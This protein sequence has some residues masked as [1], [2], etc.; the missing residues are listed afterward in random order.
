VKA[1]RALSRSGR[2]RLKTAVTSRVKRKPIAAVGGTTDGNSQG[3]ANA[4]PAS[5]AASTMRPPNL[6][7]SD[8]TTGAGWTVRNASQSPRATENAPSSSEDDIDDSCNSVISTNTCLCARRTAAM[9]RPLS[10]AHNLRSWC[11]GGVLPG[12]RRSACLAAISNSSMKGRMVGAL[13]LL[14]IR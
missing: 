14:L 1:S 4:P 3:I 8:C 2:T 9:L 5:S 13:T 12:N 11:P 10:D 6:R 7:I